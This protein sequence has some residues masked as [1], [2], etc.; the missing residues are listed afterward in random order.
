[1]LRNFLKEK[2]GWGLEK[3][4]APAFMKEFE[5]IDPNTDETIFLS[6][7]K[8]Y[9]VFSIGDRQFYFNRLTGSF[10]GVGSRVTDCV[11]GRVEFPD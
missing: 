7:G 1:M 10:D 9:S 11:S 6:T 4:K 2:A 8:T 3:L 5:Y